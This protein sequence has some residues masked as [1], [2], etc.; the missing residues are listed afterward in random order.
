MQKPKRIRR[1]NE[2]IEKRFA[3][4][5]DRCGKKYASDGS[6]Q[7]HLKLKHPEEYKQIRNKIGLI[8]P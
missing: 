8:S 1:T 4:M 2:N 3:C 7:Q 6:L 5:I